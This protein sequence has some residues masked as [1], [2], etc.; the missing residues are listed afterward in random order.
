MIDTSAASPDKS[1]LLGKPT[2]PSVIDFKYE[3]RYDIESVDD[4][5]QRVE[6]SYYHSLSDLQKDFGKSLRFVAR[7]LVCLFGLLACVR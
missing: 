4:I 5:W 6:Y 7:V 3:S 2:S 1:M